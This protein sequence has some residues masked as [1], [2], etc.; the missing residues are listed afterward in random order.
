MD[1]KDILEKAIITT[2]QA[3]DASEPGNQGYGKGGFEYQLMAYKGMLKA[4]NDG[5]FDE[6]WDKMDDLT[7]SQN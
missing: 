1:A 5:D 6:A 4:L 7:H 2:E 3:I